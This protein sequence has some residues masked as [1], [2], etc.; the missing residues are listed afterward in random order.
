M[1]K[2]RDYSLEHEQIQDNTIIYPV[3]IN[4]EMKRSFIAYA[5][6][7]NVSRAIPDVRDGLKPVHRRILYSMNETGIT[8]DKPHKKCARIVGD[9]LGKYH[10]HGDSSVYG[11]LV[12]LAQDFAIRYPLVEGHGNFGSV[13]GD[14]PAA[15]RY[16]EARLSKLADE[17]LR[18]IDKETVDFSPN[19]DASLKQPDVLPSRFP[20]LLVNGSDGIAVGMATNI[21]P[22]NLGEVVEAVVSEINNPDQT[23]EDIMKVLPA[24]DYPTGGVIMGTEALRQAYLTG[25]G[26]VV[27]RSKA[28]I[29]EDNDGKSRIVVTEIPYQVNKSEMI[30]QIADMVKN[31]RIDGIQDIREESDRHGMRLVFDVKRDFNAQVVLN[32]LYKKTQ[33]QSSY[34]INFLALVDGYPKVLNIKQ[35]LDYYIAHQKDVIYRRTKYDLA[36]AEEREHIIEG[37]VVALANIDEVIK[38]IKG[39]KDR[40]DASKNL[41][42]KFML[43]QIQAGAILDMRLQ[44]L[45]SLEV[46][47]LNKELADLRALITE[48][49]GILA[50]EDKI[51]QIIIKELEEI[52]EIYGDERKTEIDYNAST[53]INIEDLI[54]KE[55]VVISMTHFGYV[56]RIPVA[57][58]RQ[59]NRGGMGSTTH[60][61]KEEDFVEH[62]FISSTHDSIL[63]FTNKGKVYTMK[64]YEIPEE[65]KT[66]RGRN[67]VNLLELE[68]DERV[69]AVLPKRANGVGFLIMATKNGLIKKTATSE[70]ESIRKTGKIAINL[71]DD[72]ELISVDFTDGTKTVMVATNDGKCIRFSEDDVKPLGRDTMGVKAIDLGKGDEMI[73]MIVCRD[74]ADILTI[75]ENGFGKRTDL[76]EYKVQNRNGKGIKAGIFNEKTGRLV[77]LK[78]V[79]ETEDVMIIANNGIIIRTAASSISKIT[80]DTI[81]VKVMRLHEGTTVSAIAIADNVAEDMTEEGD[82]E[83]IVINDRVEE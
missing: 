34:G 39:S 74:D 66:S 61:P 63:F 43:S 23:I 68:K 33:L 70:F 79:S 73:D 59:Q 60:K 69:Q 24:P 8:S 27:I 48:Y 26:G 58:Y 82:E 71:A 4:T 1:A 7:V 11:A 21:P 22:H 38:I 52:K 41:Q 81:G 3:E 67:L 32:T 6:A 78:Q 18:D 13:D 15:Y 45:T 30:K 62:M 83:P 20:N 31:K 80:R 77:G 16:T 42:E 2:K 40:D 54:E 55:D 10:P 35:I 65:A 51:K 37:L 14:P 46:E 25:K 75:T 49:R 53:D 76:S 5:M 17:M 29:E 57:E 64:G 44:R 47:K 28:E 50:S 56:K 72:D 19:F 36:K 12:R 9:V